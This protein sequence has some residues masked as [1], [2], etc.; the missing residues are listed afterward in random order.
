MKI[1]SISLKV[2]LIFLLYILACL[3]ALLLVG[4]A[5]DSLEFSDFVITCMKGVK[6]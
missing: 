5:I 3:L 6:I 4:M 1:S 2:I